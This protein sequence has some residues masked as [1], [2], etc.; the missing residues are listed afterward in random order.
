MDDPQERSASLAYE[1]LYRL[2]VFG[3]QRL[4]EDGEST[5]QFF[6]SY[7]ELA[8]RYGVAHSLIAQYS[9]KHNCL[10]RR[11]QAQSRISAKVEA[12]I[13][14]A[15]ATALA[16][17]KEDALRMIDTFL[18]EFEEALNESGF[19]LTTLPTSTP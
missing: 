4:C 2:L 8:E 13:I 5:T 11:E 15:R 9:R 10:R 6:P 14:E 18:L 17:E 3:E 7:R 19:A 12:K 1:D 16:L